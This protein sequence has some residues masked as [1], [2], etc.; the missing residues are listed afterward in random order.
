MVVADVYFAPIMYK[1]PQCRFAD[2]SFMHLAINKKHSVFIFMKIFVHIVRI[3]KLLLI[4]LYFLDGPG[5]TL[6]FEGQEDHLVPS[7]SKVLLDSGLFVV[8]GR[9]VG[10][11]F[12]HGGPRLTGL[13]LAL[14]DENLL[15][16]QDCPDI[17]LREMVETVS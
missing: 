5:K 8:A 17:D 15:T 11:S 10:H 7:T 2:R 13:S 6:L 12:V 16:Y 9:M 14:F 3:I 1:T 4:S